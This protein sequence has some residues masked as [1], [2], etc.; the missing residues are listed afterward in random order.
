VPI[1]AAVIVAVSCVVLTNCVAR[2]AAPQYTVELDTNPDLVT[3]S[4]KAPLSALVYAGDIL[5]KTG[6]GFGTVS[7]AVL[8]TLRL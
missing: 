7:T 8:E 6:T 4:G 1:S 2:A 5:F 3:V